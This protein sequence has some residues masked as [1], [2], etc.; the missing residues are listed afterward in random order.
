VGRTT[1][2]ADLNRVRE[3]VGE[4]ELEIEGRTHVGLVLR[5]PELQQRLLILRHHYPTAYDHHPS[6]QRIEQAVAG[7]TATAG[8]SAAWG[9]CARSTA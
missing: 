1:V 6:W 2:V 7:P 9:T 4:W 8:A 3:H 5:G